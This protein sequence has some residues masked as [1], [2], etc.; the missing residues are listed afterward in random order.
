VGSGIAINISSSKSVICAG[1]SASITASSAIN[2]SWNTLAT[3]SSIVVNSSV[4]TSY[5][6][7]G[8]NSVTGCS[9]TNSITIMVNASP[10][11]SINSATSTIC[12]GQQI[13]LTANGA[14]K[15]L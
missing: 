14:N 10:S 13:N 6:V 5:N 12:S 3:T 8:T 1:Q 11:V 2:Y 7:S 15:Y 9:N 4:T